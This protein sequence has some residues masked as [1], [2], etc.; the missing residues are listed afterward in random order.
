MKRLVQR[1]R[2]ELKRELEQ[3]GQLNEAQAPSIFVGWIGSGDTVLRSGEDRNRIAKEHDVIVFEMEGAGVWGE[4]P[5]IVVKAICDY[6]D[7]HK[8][9]LG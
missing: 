7:S 6:A 3:R 1:K 5:C 2:L 9:K 8:N 4:I